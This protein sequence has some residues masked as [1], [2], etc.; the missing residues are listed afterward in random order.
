MDFEV[1]EKKS[2][3]KSK[4]ARADNDTVGDEFKNANTDWYSPSGIAKNRQVMQ[5][6]SE[7]ETQYLRT[8]NL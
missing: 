5:E 7:E 4:E 8:S 3:K 1:S 2:I 6:T